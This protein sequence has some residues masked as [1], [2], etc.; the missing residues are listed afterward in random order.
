M[1]QEFSTTCWTVILDAA[2]TDA[3][4]SRP[5]LEVLCRQYWEP[6]YAYARGCGKNHP[7]AEDTT[8]SFFAHLLGTNLP[9]RAA[10]ERGRFRSFLLTSLKNFM[11]SE[12]KSASTQK[13]GG[14][15]PAPIALEDAPKNA[16][17]LQTSETPATAYDR[18]W[19]HTVINL[20][21]DQL[22]ADQAQLGQAARFAVLRPLLLDP[23]RGSDRHTHALESLGITDGALRTAL[24]RLRTDF[25]SLVRQEVA[26]LVDDPSEIDDEISYLLRAMQA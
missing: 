24:S 3:S 25:R 20:A 1:S 10:P 18:K 17:A 21:L 14:A 2:K 9:G 22:A 11:V 26:R 4:A 13:R 6:L 12:H 8:Q 16:S 19:A 7:D 5:A 23:T 15:S